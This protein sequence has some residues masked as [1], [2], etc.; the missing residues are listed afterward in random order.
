MSA[1]EGCKLLCNVQRRKSPAGVKQGRLRKKGSI[2]VK[3]RWRC[4]CP[5]K[6]ARPRWLNKCTDLG[7]ISE[8][9]KPRKAHFYGS[10]IEKKWDKSTKPSWR[11]TVEDLECQDKK[12]RLHLAGREGA[13]KDLEWFD[14]WVRYILL[15][16]HTH[17]LKYKGKKV[18]EAQLEWPHSP[19]SSQEHGGWGEKVVMGLWRQGKGLK[20][21]RCQSQRL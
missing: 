18:G 20:W 19:V 14:L 8:C 11:Q 1:E 16:I 21:E 12:F 4:K 7:I 13:N 10:I 15:N 2:W 5:G 17:I 6:R 9:V 3:G